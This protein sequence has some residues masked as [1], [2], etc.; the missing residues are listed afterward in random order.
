M[1]IKQFKRDP[2]ATFYYTNLYQEAGNNK[3][4]KTLTKSISQNKRNKMVV[5]KNSFTK[6]F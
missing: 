4:G 2:V 3:K 5:S 1:L 6:E